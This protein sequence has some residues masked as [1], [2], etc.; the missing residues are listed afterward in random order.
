MV[1]AV[2]QLDV[3]VIIGRASAKTRKRSQMPPLSLSS[4]ARTRMDGPYFCLSCTAPRVPY[5]VALCTYVH[6]RRLARAP[7]HAS[8]SMSSTRGSTG[9]RG[10][11][12]GAKAS[13][14]ADEVAA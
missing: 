12:V 2:R 1:R 5:S 11:A 14:D 13:V 3:T 9:G 4:P 6:T 7:A 8:P 10:P